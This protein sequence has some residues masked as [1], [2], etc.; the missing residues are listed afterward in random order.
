VPDA[1]AQ[2]RTLLALLGADGS[3]GSMMQRAR[4]QLP[5]QAAGCARSSPSGGARGWRWVGTP[6]PATCWPG[7][8]STTRW[9]LPGPLSPGST[10]LRCRRTTWWCCPTSR[11]PSPPTTGRRRSLRPVRAGVGPA[12]HVVRPL[13][14]RGAHRARRAAGRGATGLSSRQG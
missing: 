2:L 4:G 11:T 8:A 9:R 14:G 5:W 7:S 13:A 10:W 12:P 1:L 3:A 6:S